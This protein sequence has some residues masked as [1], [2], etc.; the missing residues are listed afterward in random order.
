VFSEFESHFSYVNCLRV[1]IKFA[2]D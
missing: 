2:S 1:G